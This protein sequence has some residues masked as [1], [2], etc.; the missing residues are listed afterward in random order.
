MLDPAEEALDPVAVA[1]EIEAEADRITAIAFWRDVGPC[2]SP[3]GELPNPIGVMA[4]VS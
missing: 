1:V 2:A 3:H 4:T